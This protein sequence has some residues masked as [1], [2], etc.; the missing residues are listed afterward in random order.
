MFF[1]AAVTLRVQSQAF[2]IGGSQSQAIEIIR[3]QA[4]EFIR[5]FD[6]IGGQCAL[7]LFALHMPVNHLRHDHFF[8]VV[9]AIKLPLIRRI[10]M[11][12]IGNRAVGRYGEDVI[13]RLSRANG[14]Q[15]R[16][17]IGMVAARPQQGG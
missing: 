2:A 14:F 1:K 16:L 6:L 10:G 13:T 4:F 11:L 17:I 15:I 9:H 7:H 5:H 3:K 12:Q 8:V